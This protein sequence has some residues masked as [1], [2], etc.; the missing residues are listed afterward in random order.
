M[1]T[2]QLL[3]AGFLSISG[4]SAR[5]V[6][7]GHNLG[8]YGYRGFYGHPQDSSEHH[9]DETS[10]D[11]QNTIESLSEISESNLQMVNSALESAEINA[12]FA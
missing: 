10:I 7:S 11:F 5:Y 8:R 1:F 9:D 6:H 3:I 12:G 4:I 2:N